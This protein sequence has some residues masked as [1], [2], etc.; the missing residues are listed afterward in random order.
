MMVIGL[1]DP[2]LGEAG[3][4]KLQQNIQACPPPILLP[5]A[6]HFVQEHG[7]SIAESAVQHFK[8]STS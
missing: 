3:M 5:Q 7:Q 8:V 1:Q 2:V 4:R 6:G